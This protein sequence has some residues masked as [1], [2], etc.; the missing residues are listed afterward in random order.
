MKANTVNPDKTVKMSDFD[1]LG[2]FTVDQSAWGN[3]YFHLWN[4]LRE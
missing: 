1:R 4:A 2:M 3:L